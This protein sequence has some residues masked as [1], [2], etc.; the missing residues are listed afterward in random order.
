MGKQRQNW[1]VEE[2]L[3]I[4]LAVLSQR[5]SVAEISCQRGMNENQI[6]RWKEQFLVASRQGLNGAKAKRRISDWT[7]RMAN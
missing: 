2:K 1:T 7:R 5:R 3:E 4:V 6:D